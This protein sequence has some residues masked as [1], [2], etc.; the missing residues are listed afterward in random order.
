MLLPLGSRLP[1]ICTAD[2]AFI[3]VHFTGYARSL[4]E[5]PG[6]KNFLVKPDVIFRTGPS[7]SGVKSIRAVNQ[8]NAPKARRRLLYFLVYARPLSQVPRRDAAGANAGLT[9]GQFRAVK[10]Q[11][12]GP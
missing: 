6:L 9:A 2:A 1:A 3:D 4:S 12:K 8:R 10:G 11:A 7:R 5:V